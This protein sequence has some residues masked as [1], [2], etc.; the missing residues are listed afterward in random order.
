MPTID[1]FVNRVPYH[2]AHDT[3]VRMQPRSTQYNSTMGGQGTTPATDYVQC[4]DRGSMKP[5]S[6]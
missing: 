3:T 6:K 1:H 2:V 4:I 5:V